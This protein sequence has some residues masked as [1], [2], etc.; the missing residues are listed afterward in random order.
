MSLCEILFS[1]REKKKKKRAWGS[2]K[3]LHVLT[4]SE[5]L[6][7]GMVRVCGTGQGGCVGPT[8]QSENRCLIFKGLIMHIPLAS[9]RITS[10]VGAACLWGRGGV[11]VWI[12][13]SP[14]QMEKCHSPWI[15]GSEDSFLRC[16]CQVTTACSCLWTLVPERGKKKPLKMKIFSLSC[17]SDCSYFSRYV[18]YTLKHKIPGFAFFSWQRR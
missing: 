15:Y 12:M 4:L 6:L 11:L 8:F 18:L 7:T 17:L 9:N 2:T 16:I 13:L 10:H 3:F 14:V 1:P 5:F